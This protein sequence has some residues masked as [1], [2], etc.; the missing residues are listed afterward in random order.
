M[1]AI[2]LACKPKLMIAD[3]PTTALDVTVQAQILELLKRLAREEGLGVMLITHNLGVVA[4][5]C[6][7]VNV[8][9]AGQIV[10]AGTTEQVL[11][12]PRHPYTER[13]LRSVPQLD[14]DL[15]VDLES[16]PG[17]PPNLADLP[18]G[19]AFHPRCPLAFDRCRIEV[20]SVRATE[21]GHVS[22]CWANE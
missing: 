3:E 2:G 5:Y 20:P 12:R 1:I 6:D 19:C 10:E 17:N 14:Q 15:S 9:Y 13:L 16:I 11:T 8:M 4:R 21:T 22:R 18:I 7:R